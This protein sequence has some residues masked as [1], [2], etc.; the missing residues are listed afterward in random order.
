MKECV[1]ALGVEC[2]VNSGLYQ[3]NQSA[4][5]ALTE[6]LTSGSALKKFSQMVVAM[7]GP[8]DFVSNYESYLPKAP[9]IRP[10]YQKKSGLYLHLM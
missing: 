4:L 2:L 5:D 10:I 9:V 8:V 1:L 3:N 6:S 7:G